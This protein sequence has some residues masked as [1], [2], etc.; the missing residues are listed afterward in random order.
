MTTDTFS[1]AESQHGQTCV[2]SI[3]GRIDS[4]NADKLMQ[5]LKAL[6]AS[7]V[8]NVLLDMGAVKYLTSAAFRV[9][10]VGNGSLKAKSGQLALCGVTGHVRNLFEM[11]GLLQSFTIF[12][13]PDEAL[14][15]LQ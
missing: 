8:R 11:G 12:E 2:L 9:L 10:L 13:S 4:G 15:K 14:R 1:I 3:T 5:K 7:D 6:A